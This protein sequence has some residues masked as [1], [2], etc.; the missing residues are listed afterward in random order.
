WRGMVPNHPLPGPEAYR[1]P[2][3]LGVAPAAALAPL[4]VGGVA[5]AVVRPPPR[6]PRPQHRLRGSPAPGSEDPAPALPPP[7]AS[8]RVRH[9]LSGLPRVS[10]AKPSSRS[11]SL[12][13]TS[14]S[15]Q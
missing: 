13:M 7:P 6:A 4:G 8:S 14:H 12:A 10:T 11:G 15:V 2:P 9:V 1:G 3:G 5:F